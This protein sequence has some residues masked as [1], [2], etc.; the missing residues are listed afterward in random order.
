MM[1]GLHGIYINCIKNLNDLNFRY[2]LIGINLGFCKEDMP[3]VYT[4]FLSYQQ[5]QEVASWVKDVS[6]P[7]RDASF[8]DTDSD[9][10]PHRAVSISV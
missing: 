2:T 8:C 7:Y 10:P 9:E 5:F 4:S 1:I 6:S 3:E